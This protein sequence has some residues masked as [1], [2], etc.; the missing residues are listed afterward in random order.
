MNYATLPQRLP[1]PVWLAVA[2]AFPCSNR[3]P[4]KLLLALAARPDRSRALQAN[5]G[6]G[7]G[8]RGRLVKKPAP[9]AG[10]LVVFALNSR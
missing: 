1:V 7:T 6:T 3:V 5:V 10:A 4:S 8:T 2:T 9:P